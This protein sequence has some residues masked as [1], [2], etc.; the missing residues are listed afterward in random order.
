MIDYNPL[1]LTPPRCDLLPASPVLTQIFGKQF[2][3][4]PLHTYL[5]FVHLQSRNTRK[6]LVIFYISILS[7]MSP[8]LKRSDDVIYFM[9]FLDI[10]FI[11]SQ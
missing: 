6:Q 5:F 2:D 9:T 10:G 11:G 7:K 1:A 3:P 8:L 4:D